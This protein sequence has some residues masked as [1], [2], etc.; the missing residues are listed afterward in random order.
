MRVAPT[1]WVTPEQDATMRRYGYRFAPRTFHYAAT[2]CVLLREPGKPDR[3]GVGMLTFEGAEHWKAWAISKEG[4]VWW[5]KGGRPVRFYPRGT[6]AGMLVSRALWDLRPVDQIVICEG[7][8]DFL[9]LIEIG[10]LKVITPGG[11]SNDSAFRLPDFS[12]WALFK[13]PREVVI[14]TDDDDAGDRGARRW[15]DEV[16]R[17]WPGATVKRLEMRALRRGPG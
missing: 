5:G 7:E 11:A 2:Y 1:G 6:R 8:T 4:R 15:L 10:I 9:S 17:I 13:K 12:K 16:V 14:V 3:T